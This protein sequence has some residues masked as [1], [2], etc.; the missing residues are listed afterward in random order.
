MEHA[1]GLTVL[2]NHC[3]CVVDL[4]AKV[5]AGVAHSVGRTLG[6]GACDDSQPTAFPNSLSVV[7]TRRRPVAV[8]SRLPLV[9]EL[10]YVSLG[11]M[12]A[13][14][15]RLGSF[16]Y[17]DGARGPSKANADSADIARVKLEKPPSFQNSG[18]G[19][20]VDELLSRVLM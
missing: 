5:L 14:Q 12:G 10:E 16:D 2:S 13:L 7:S 20:A 3:K 15:G 1:A 18:L 17:Q 19:Q 4:V 11:W 9:S 8:R 6:Q